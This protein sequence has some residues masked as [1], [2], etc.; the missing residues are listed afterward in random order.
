MK[1][2]SAAFTDKFACSTA[3]SG[4]PDCANEISKIIDRLNQTREAAELLA[5][6]LNRLDARLSGAPLLNEKRETQKPIPAGA[7]GAINER[8]D[9][10]TDRLGALRSTLD[11][12]DTIG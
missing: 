9:D 3:A 8:L 7:I 11:H 4:G 2:Q 6:R 1:M 10:I 5:D 12:L